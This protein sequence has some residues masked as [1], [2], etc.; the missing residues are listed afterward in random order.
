MLLSDLRQAEDYALDLFDFHLE[1]RNKIIV[2]IL[3]APL[4]TE[5]LKNLSSDSL[6]NVKESLTAN[7]ENL[8]TIIY[9]T[10]NSFHNPNS[11]VIDP[12][13]WEQSEYHPTPTIIQ[14][15]KALFAGQKVEAIT[16]TEAES[17]N[18][19]KVTNYIIFNSLRVYFAQLA[20]AMVHWV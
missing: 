4:A 7:Q 5:K 14:A 13:K 3:I 18:I 11:Q 20:V 10:F 2:P 15:A 19:F 8:S 1:S 17:K 16:K 12:I 6:K 9:K